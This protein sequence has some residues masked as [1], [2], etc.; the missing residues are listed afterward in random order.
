M[1][2]AI[3]CDADGFCP[4]VS[5]LFA[6]IIAKTDTLP[7]WCL[8]HDR[9]SM[10]GFCNKEIDAPSDTTDASN[11]W[12]RNIYFWEDGDIIQAIQGI[13]C[14]DVKFHDFFN[15]DLNRVSI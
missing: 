1:S 4:T 2:R 11:V 13:R 7:K 9:V 6:T 14:I 3:S 10:S 8:R 15:N 12:M 5:Y